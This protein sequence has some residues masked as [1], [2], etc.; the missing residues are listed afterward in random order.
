M[1]YWTYLVVDLHCGLQGLKCMC[2][3]PTGIK[4]THFSWFKCNSG[5]GEGDPA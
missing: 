3:P 2:K 5:V 4:P 1:K